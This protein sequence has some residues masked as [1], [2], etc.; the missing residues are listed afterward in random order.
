MYSR[1]EASELRQAFWTAFGQ[2][3]GPVPGA[4]GEKVNWVNYK[5]GE[6][7]IAFRMDADKRTASVGIV[8]SHKDAGLRQLYFEQFQQLKSAFDAAV[9]EEWDWLPEAYDDWGAPVSKITFSREGLNIF[10]KEDWPELISFFKTRIV[11]LD[12]FWSEVKYFFEA[13]R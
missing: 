13:L 7:G 6:K 1:K 2:Y 5:T 8:L 4:E 12:A 9:G 3:M 11:A 10:R